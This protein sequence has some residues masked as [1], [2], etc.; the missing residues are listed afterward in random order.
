V[1]FFGGKSIDQQLE[2]NSEDYDYVR[3]LNNVEFEQLDLNVQCYDQNE[4]VDDV[5]I[6]SIQDQHNSDE[7]TDEEPDPP[8]R[9]QRGKEI[10]GNIEIIFSSTRK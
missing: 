4:Y 8:I 5:I 3:V 2:P 6:Q 7:D 9:L 10:F 1:W